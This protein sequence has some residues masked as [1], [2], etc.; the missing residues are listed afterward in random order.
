MKRQ[1]SDYTIQAVAHALDLLEQFQGDDDELGVTELSRRLGLHKNNV[2]R[3]LATLEARGYIEQNGE[4]GNYRLGLKVLELGQTFIRQAGMLRQSDV[5]LHELVGKVN[6]TAYVAVVRDGMAVYLN[7]VEPNRTVRVVSRV[8]HR[9]PIFATAVGKS[10]AAFWSDEEI[11]SALSQYPPRSYTTKTITE[12]DKIME[13]LKETADQGWALDDEEYEM[14]VRCVAAPVYDYTR[15]VR[16]SVSVSGPSSRM[17][18][19]R[20]HDEIVPAILEA[21]LQ[22]S[23]QLGYEPAKSS[24]SR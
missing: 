5:L 11:R 15:R 7:G 2:F 16:G 24:A 19:E 6:E 18:P 23:H 14:G 1:K 8:G 10:H 20:I 12:S 22:L 9:L 21:A 13:K 17:T 3:L 4:S